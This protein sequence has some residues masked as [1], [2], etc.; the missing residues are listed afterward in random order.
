MSG[1]SVK[2]LYWTQLFHPYIGGVEVLGVEYVRAL[3]SRGHE[4]A[5]VTS[6]GSLDL[7][8][9]DVI[10]G[11]RSIG[12]GSPKPSSAGIRAPFSPPSGGSA[13]SRAHSP[14]TSCISS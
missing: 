11:A 13:R 14:R 9:Q 4:V 3:R 5:I 10:A 12:F 7:P 2:I 6:H 1:A 8:D